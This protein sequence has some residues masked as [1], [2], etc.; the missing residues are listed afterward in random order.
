MYNGKFWLFVKQLVTKHQSSLKPCKFYEQNK[1]AVDSE[2]RNFI[3]KTK[4]HQS[5]TFIEPKY[6]NYNST[7]TN[8]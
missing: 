5:P 4:H 2:Y 7:K 3:T 6:K 1:N 8:L